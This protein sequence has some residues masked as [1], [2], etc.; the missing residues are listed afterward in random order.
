M[1]VFLVVS[2]VPAIPVKANG[3]YPIIVNDGG[4]VDLSTELNV[5]VGVSGSYIYEITAEE[6]GKTLKKEGTGAGITVM[7][8]WS[9]TPGLVNHTANDWTFLLNRPVTFTIVVKNAATGEVLNV[10]RVA[11]KTYAPKLAVTPSYVL[12]KEAPTKEVTVRLTD[13]DLNDLGNGYR[14]NFFGFIVKDQPIVVSNLPQGAF[15]VL[16][17]GQTAIA[18]VTQTLFFQEELGNDG[19]FTLR[20]NLSWIKYAFKDGDVVTFKWTDY[21]TGKVVTYDVK[22]VKE[23]P[24]GVSLD[25]NLYPLP[26]QGVFNIT[27][28]VTDPNPTGVDPSLFWLAL[29]RWDGLPL[30]ITITSTGVSA[31]LNTT[32]EDASNAIKFYSDT[33]EITK[34][35]YTFQVNLTEAAR[36]DSDFPVYSW[37]GADVVAYYNGTMVKATIQPS[38]AVLSVDK[39]AVKVNDTITITLIDPDANLDSS[40]N[41]TVKVAIDKCCS[42]TL[43]LKETGENT[44][45]FVGKVVIN[46]NNF[47]TLNPDKLPYE[48][49]ITYMDSYT[50]FTTVSA[51]RS[52]TLTQKVTVTPTTAKVWLGDSEGNPVTTIG[53]YAKLY[54]Y[55]QD[56]D[57]ILNSTFKLPDT[58]AIVLRST[59][60][61][62]VELTELNQSDEDPTL[63]YKE[64]TV[65]KMNGTAPSDSGALEVVSPDTIVVRAVDP[66]AEPDGSA[67][68]FLFNIAV[69]TWDGKVYV[70]PS[71]PFYLDGETIWIYVEDPDAN[72]NLDKR[73]T[74]TVRITSTSDPVGIELPL[75]ETGVSTGV[76]RAPFLI[77]KSQMA[78]FLSD[79]DKI[80]ISYTDALS[81]TGKQATFTKELQF[82]FVTAT[83]I[84]P[85]APAAVKFLDIMGNEVA[86]KVGQPTLIQIPVSNADTTRSV[87]TD[88]IIVFYDAN[89]VP[90]G[91]AYGRITL[92]AGASGTAIVGWLPSLAGTFTAKVFFWDLANKVPLSEQPLLL[93]VTVQ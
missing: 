37:T 62:Q 77:S 43:E 91:L 20:F 76:F 49:E 3:T 56:P 59:T 64:I 45:V 24:M 50:A 13:N 33:S 86:P 26:N 63:F 35:I 79:G 21:Y 54:V 81:A 87:T 27:A 65:K 4:V 92:G 51:P 6:I 52:Q 85:G 73:D 72:A 74:V 42:G 48:I 15:E 29:V 66:S 39:T 11:M 40:L 47:P 10:T 89:N 19:N 71:K 31:Y 58:Y 23:L 9:S 78:P 57:Y 90:V 8:N 88:V 38:T 12:V 28:T 1:L 5:K 67:K 7:L 17:N 93:T 68:V 60:G 75:V 30:N 32:G 53:P 25:R 44:G 61:D 34:H 80:I 84:K 46:F 22:I 55:F 36:I 2:I 41:D 69:R 14:D 83:P 82:G 16:V 70:E 18:N